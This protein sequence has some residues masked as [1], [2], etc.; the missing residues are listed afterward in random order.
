MTKNEK[1]RLL[2][3]SGWRLDGGV[4]KY[5]DLARVL[6]LTLALAL[7]EVELCHRQRQLLQFCGVFLT[8]HTTLHTHMR[9]YT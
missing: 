9:T 7:V 5:D 8:R 6:A 2:A 3:E 4:K 1:V